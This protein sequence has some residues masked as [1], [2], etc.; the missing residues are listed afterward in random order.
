MNYGDWVRFNSAQRIVLN[1]IESFP[2][3]IS[4]SFLSSFYFA[5]IACICVWGVVL[6]RILFVI[7]YK[8]SPQY[9]IPGALLIQLSNWTLIILTFVSMFM[10]ISS[11]SKDAE[12][13]A[14]TEEAQALIIQ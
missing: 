4:F 9:R 14:T 2:M 7:G 5:T 13:P 10:L 3:L 1:Y 11:G 6:A 8:K 12:A